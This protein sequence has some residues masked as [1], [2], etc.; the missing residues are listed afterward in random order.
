MYVQLFLNSRFPRK[1][2]V[3]V[4]M[5]WLKMTYGVTNKNKGQGLKV[6]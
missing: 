5:V 4:D 2:S 1:F 3:A 6:L